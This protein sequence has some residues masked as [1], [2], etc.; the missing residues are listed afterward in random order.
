MFLPVKDREKSFYG[1]S[2]ESMDGNFS[3]LR[4]HQTSNVGCSFCTTSTENHS[5]CF[6]DEMSRWKKNSLEQACQTQ[7]A[8]RA[9]QWV[10]KAQN[11]SAGRS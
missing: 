7:I 3:L 8:M 6:V 1:G 4:N 5:D 11:L 10:L 9:A 2:K